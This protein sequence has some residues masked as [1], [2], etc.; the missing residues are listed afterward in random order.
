MQTIDIR[1]YIVPDEDVFYYRF[2]GYAAT[3]PKDIYAALRNAKG[4]PVTARI[5]SYGGDVWSGSE[6]YT[7]LREYEPGVTTVATGL[8]ASA[9][10]IILMAG[11]TVRASPTAEIM[12]HNPSSRASG[13]HRA[14]EQA[15]K[16]LRN[17]REAIVNAYELKT[18]M[19]RGKLRA[20]LNAE[21]WMTAQSA[22]EMGFIDEILFDEEG[23]LNNA[24]PEADAI[25]TGAADAKAAAFSM[26]SCA[27]LRARYAVWNEIAPGARDIDEA[28]EMLAQSKTSAAEPP[29]QDEPGAAEPAA[30]PEP[31]GDEGKNDIEMMRARIAA[32]AI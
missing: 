5:N 32:L 10:S 13:D 9:A 31:Q 20:M 11:N 2:F 27:E 4:E 22:Q 12:I 7:T 19:G 24:E 3:A 16:S 25:E 14:M 21:T 17:T 26:P 1:G 28:R 15:A 8:A 18:G 6:I 23:K 30:D 29:A